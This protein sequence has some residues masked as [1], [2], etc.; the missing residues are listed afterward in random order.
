MILQL[1]EEG[2]WEVVPDPAVP[3]G[4][5][6]ASGDARREAFQEATLT[7]LTDIAN[8]NRDIVVELRT[9]NGEAE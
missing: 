5:R 9:L 8:R 1:N 7:L 2:R 4:V 3:D 6:S